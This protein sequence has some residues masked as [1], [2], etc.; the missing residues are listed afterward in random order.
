MSVKKEIK[1]DFQRDNKEKSVRKYIKTIRFNER[2]LSVIDQFCDKFNIQS[3]AGFFR[4]TI[5]KSILEQLDDS[6]PRLF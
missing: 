1:P 3:K 6:H 2:E 4:E 5:I